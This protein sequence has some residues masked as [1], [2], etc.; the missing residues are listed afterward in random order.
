MGRATSR[1]L[2][3]PRS[4]SRPAAGLVVTRRARASAARPFEPSAFFAKALAP[5]LPA[6]E[7]PSVTRV[8][9]LASDVLDAVAS[10]ALP[11]I[12]REDV[13]LAVRISVRSTREIPSDLLAVRE[14][15][16][17]APPPAVSV[18]RVTAESDEAIAAGSEVAAIVTG[19]W[20][21]PDF[22]GD[23]G[24]FARDP[25]SGRPLRT[26]TR[27]IGFVLA[28]PRAAQLGP[29][30]VTLYQHGNPGSAEEEVVEQARRSLAAAGF[31]VI[32]FTDVVN[33]EVSPPG[34]DLEQ[35]AQ[36][37]VR[38][39]LLH[40]LWYQRARLLGETTPAARLPARDPVA[41]RTPRFERATE[42][43]PAADLHRRRA[44]LTVEGI[45]GASL[46]ASLLPSLPKCARR[47]WSW[48]GAATA[49]C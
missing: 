8:R 19:T 44:A 28:L 43:A 30:P 24:T 18:L 47:R 9:A 27:P 20:E 38:E 17:S 7:D 42:R 48:A 33:R 2:L 1:A 29:V 25:V 3:F 12:P 49:R 31:A 21:A 16:F 23:D 36:L 5:A 40:L 13:A 14:E 46:A 35:R 26:H 41:R 6:G 10:A 4:R 37:Q 32:G 39:L 34:A 45:S 15:I 22:R 11:P